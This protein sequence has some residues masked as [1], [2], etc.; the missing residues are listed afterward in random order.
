M[1]PKLS[2]VAAGAMLA[3]S[4]SWADTITF[5]TPEEQPDRVAVQ[6]QMAAAFTAKTGHEVE[7]VPVSEKD[8]GTRATA[9]F[10]LGHID[11]P[12]AK[13]TLARFINDSDQ[14]IRKIAQ[15]AAKTTRAASHPKKA[16]VAVTQ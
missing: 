13:Q 6:E 2:L 4:A 1:F 11:H 15:S 9:A 12:Q 16:D 3:A 10:A 7:V 5:W 8:L 14:R